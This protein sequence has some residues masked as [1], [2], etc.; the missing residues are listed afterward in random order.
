MLYII[1]IGGV[2]KLYGSESNGF[3]SLSQLDGEEG[4]GVCKDDEVRGPLHFSF[5]VYFVYDI[6]LYHLPRLDKYSHSVAL[7]FKR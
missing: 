5:Q 3:R 6:I 2:D 4:Y 1:Q 7:L